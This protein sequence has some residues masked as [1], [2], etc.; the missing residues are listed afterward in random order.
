MQLSCLPP[1]VPISFL[2]NEVLQRSLRPPSRKG[3]SCTP[4]VLLISAKGCTSCEIIGGA[5]AALSAWKT[6]QRGL[7]NTKVF[8]FS[9]SFF[10]YQEKDSCT[11]ENPRFHLADKAFAILTCELDLLPWWWWGIIH[12]RVSICLLSYLNTNWM[13]SPHLPKSCLRLQKE[14]SRKE[15]KVK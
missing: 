8:W 11:V 4:V 9:H 14:N 12:C 7:I 3:E 6:Y 5:I 15:V 2:N 13:N 10:Y 1:L